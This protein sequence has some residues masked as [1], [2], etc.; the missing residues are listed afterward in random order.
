MSET[1]ATVVAILGGDYCRAI[2]LLFVWYL[3]SEDI[4]ERED[5]RYFNEA[6]ADFENDGPDKLLSQSLNLFEEQ[7]SSVQSRM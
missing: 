2:L 1:F 5:F 6:F 7:K 4:W 3:W